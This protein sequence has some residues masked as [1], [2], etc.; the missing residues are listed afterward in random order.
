VL[1]LAAS[2]AAD[3]ALRELLAAVERT[4]AA[5]DATGSAWNS[6]WSSIVGSESTSAAVRSDAHAMRS[7]YDSL[8]VKRAKLETDDDAR[9]F[10]AT[11]AQNTDTSQVEAV[12]AFTSLGGGVKT[13]AADT[14]KDAGRELAAVGGGWLTVLKASP[15]LVAGFL[16][17]VGWSWFGRRRS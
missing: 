3:A 17:V 9:A 5:A 7:L 16:L 13:I 12:A 2:S 15:Y 8:R 11:V 14:A 10:I 6:A 1:S 4:E